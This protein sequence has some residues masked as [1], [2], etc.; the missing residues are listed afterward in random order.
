[1]EECKQGEAKYTP[2]ENETVYKMWSISSSFQ[3]ADDKPVR[4]HICT[5]RRV[6]P[7]YKTGRGP[8]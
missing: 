1:M 5:Y 3:S 4:L 2:L 7:Y 8:I 6:D